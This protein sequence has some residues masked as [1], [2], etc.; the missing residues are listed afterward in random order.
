MRVVKIIILNLIIPILLFFIIGIIYF[1]TNGA[2]GEYNEKKTSY[3]EMIYFAIG[4]LHICILAF[5]LKDC[6]RNKFIYSLIV[7]ITYFYLAFVFGK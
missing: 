5:F 3:V 1:I 2:G 6:L 7:L 4:I